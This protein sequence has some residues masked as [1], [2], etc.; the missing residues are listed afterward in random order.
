MGAGRRQPSRAVGWCAASDS[1][2]SIVLTGT[3]EQSCASFASCLAF[4]GCAALSAHSSTPTST[5]ICCPLRTEVW[6]LGAV[7]GTPT[8]PPE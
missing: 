2:T 3:E 8:V 7:E 5:L 4:L 6:D 1:S